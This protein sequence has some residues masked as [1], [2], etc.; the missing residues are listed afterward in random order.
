[1]SPAVR[2]GWHEFR[3]QYVE[4]TPIAEAIIA[5][6]ALASISSQA[7]EFAIERQKIESAFYTR[8]LTDL[9][10]LAKPGTRLSNRLRDFHLV[11]FTQLQVEIKR[12]LKA[13]IPVKQRGEW[14]ALHAEAS[15]EI[16][17]LNAAIAAAEAEINRLVYEAFELTAGE[18]ELLENSLKGQV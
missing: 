17:R 15:A 8:L 11:D 3:S 7:T 4:T 9:T 1:M 5:N 13:T 16:H 10:D 18:I 2:N 6:K 14:Q 12:A